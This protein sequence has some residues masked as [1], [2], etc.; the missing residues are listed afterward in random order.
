MKLNNFL[1]PSSIAI[2]GASDHID[3]V[4]GIL[5]K[6]ALK[7]QCKIIP[8]NPAHSELFGIKCYSHLYKYPERIDLA[9]IA[10]PK[11]FVYKAAEE[12]IDNEVKD[13]I[14][15]SAGFSEVGNKEE[16]DKLMFLARKHGAR[17]LGPNCFGIFSSNEN[18]DLTFSNKTPKKGKI[19]FISQSGAL[20]SYLADLGMG[21]SGFVGL[22]N[23][24]DLEFSDFI[25]HYTNDKN[26]DSLVLYIEKIKHGKRFIEAC[27][28]A[29]DKGKKIFAVKAGKTKEG[30]KATFSHTASLASEYEIYRGA[31][32]QAGVELCVSLEEAISKASVKKFKL[33]KK[34]VQIR[35][36]DIITNAGGAG[37]LVSDYLFERN[38]KIVS[39][40][41]ILG[42]ASAIDY[43]NALDKTTAKEVIVILTAQSM[44]EIE[45]TAHIISDFLAK[46]GKNIIPV[47]LGKKSMKEANKILEKNKIKY[48]NDLESFRQSLN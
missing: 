32:R 43:Y 19:A 12:C 17:I 14:I 18:L 36:V 3:K 26:T 4:G 23:M 22:G 6:K 29:L 34:K 16:E 38:V 35:N 1:N 31:F 37:A 33:L 39:R 30:E 48:F 11:E 44:S 21:F 42:T 13:I 9:I 8:V 28:N 24:V 10:I 5:M 45:K 40:K 41:D 46:T 27:K 15:V 20:W 7:S 25:E 47:F 2:I